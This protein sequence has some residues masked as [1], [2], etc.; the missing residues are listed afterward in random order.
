VRRV[1]YSTWSTHEQDLIL[2]Q[3]PLSMNLRLHL[4][5]VLQNE[6]GSKLQHS[7]HI[8]PPDKV[9]CIDVEVEGGVELTDNLL[10]PIRYVA[11]HLCQ[12][13][14]ITGILDGIQILVPLGCHSFPIDS[15]GLNDG[16][17]LWDI[18]RLVPINVEEGPKNINQCTSFSPSRP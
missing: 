14:C 8:L 12:L 16:L 5:L 18:H 13:K 4:M 7:D 17:P 9:L 3:G 11:H 15:L 2:M 1:R 10:A 6:Q